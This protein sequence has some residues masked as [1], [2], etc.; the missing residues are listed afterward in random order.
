MRTESDILK[1]Q[2]ALKAHAKKIVGGGSAQ[3]E[4]FLLHL[5]I[6]KVS[7][8]TVLMLLM[9]IIT[10]DIIKNHKKETAI[11]EKRNKAILREHSEIV[12]QIIAQ[13]TEGAKIAMRNHLK[14]ISD[15]RL[16]K[17]ST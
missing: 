7:G 5:E 16:R 15:F 1:I 11:T 8:N 9:R 13:N 4:D 2:N 6:A 12:D 14:G 10:P 17:K 3:E